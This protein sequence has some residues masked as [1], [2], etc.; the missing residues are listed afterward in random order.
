MERRDARKLKPEAQEEIRRQAVRLYKQRKTRIEIGEYLEVNRQTVGRWIRKYKEEGKKSLL[1]QKRGPKTG[2]L[3]QLNKETQ[4]RIVKAISKNF[5]D[6]LKLPFALW[7]REAVGELIKEYTGKELDLRQVGRYLKRWGFTPQRPVKQ[8]YQRNEKKVKKWLEEEY[9]SIKKAAKKQGGSIHWVDESGIKSHDHRGR[10]YSPKGQTPIR[11]H[12]PNGEKINQISAITNQGK[13]R[14]MCYESNFN[15]RVYHR[16]LKQLILDSK[17]KKVFVIA[18][19][20]RVHHSKVIKRWASIHKNQIEL[21]YLPA[22][23][24]DLNPDEYFNGDL[25]RELAKRPERR[26]KGQWANTVKNTLQAFVD[27]PDR[28]KSYFNADKIKYAA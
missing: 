13:L 4:D 5:P 27:Q 8:A 19:N 9:P 21:H 15:Y 25:K 16:F 18:D 26:V 6:Q 10:G 23:C 20:L 22:Y 2:T 28:I 12:N 3:L 24:P 17:G 14:F 1:L 11:K 7:T